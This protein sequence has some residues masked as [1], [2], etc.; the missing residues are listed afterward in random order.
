M[1]DKRSHRQ[2]D[3][4]ALVTLVAVAAMLAVSF[5]NVWSIRRLGER[6][7]AIES[8]TRPAQASGP[9]Q[10]RLYVV[11]TAGAQAKGPGAAPVT[12]VEFSDFQCPF[13]AKVLPTVRRIQDT[14]GQTVRVVWKHMPLPNH[15]DAVAAAVA[16][17]AAGKQGKFWEFH[18]LLF[19]N[20]VRLQPDALTRYAREL[21]LDVPRFE[22]DRGAADVRKRVDADA[23][24]ALAMGIDGTP[25]FFINGRFISGAQ[26]F[27]VFSTLIDEE[28][29]K[30][31]I[32][33]P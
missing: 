4:V 21:G 12:I 6:V 5:V 7:A 9:Q 20:Q 18:D 19:A 2:V 15:R 31:S 1:E 27:E 30:R 14:Y 25:A 16:A 28:L 10:D 17:E 23:A 24:E 3:G 33:K 13:C 32:S 29:A 26:P 11:N 22:A 8:R